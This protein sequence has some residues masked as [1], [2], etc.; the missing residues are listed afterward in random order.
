VFFTLYFVGIWCLEFGISQV[1]GY[2][3]LELIISRMTV[4]LSIFYFYAIA[5]IIFTNLN[6][7]NS[8]KIKSKLF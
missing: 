3:Q 5:I 7:G 1:R 4:A 2:P 8:I 6:L